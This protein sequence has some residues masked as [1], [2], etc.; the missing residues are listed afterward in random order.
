MLETPDQPGA[1]RPADGLDRPEPIHPARLR[2]LRQ[3]EVTDL[4]PGI[5]LGSIFCREAM[6]LAD[7]P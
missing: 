5:E 7:Q 1:M 4:A 6:I 3:T 2:C